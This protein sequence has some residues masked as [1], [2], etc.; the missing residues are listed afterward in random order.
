MLWARGTAKKKELVGNYNAVGREYEPGGRPV[1][2]NTHDFSVKQLGKMVPTGSTTSA[3]TKGTS[4]S[5]SAP[6][7]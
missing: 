7:R 1:A 5:G 2:V 4:R 3:A 6:T